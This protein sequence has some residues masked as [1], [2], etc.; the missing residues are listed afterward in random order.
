MSEE[1]FGVVN[2]VVEI[3][4]VTVMVLMNILILTLRLVL[5]N[6][7]VIVQINIEFFQLRFDVQT[8]P[9]FNLTPFMQWTIPLEFSFTSNKLTLLQSVEDVGEVGYVMKAKVPIEVFRL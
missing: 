7:F 3:F 5:E 9:H 6:S 8:Q 2:S 4:R 1:N